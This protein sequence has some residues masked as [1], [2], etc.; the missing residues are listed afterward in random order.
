MAF[1]SGVAHAE[2]VLVSDNVGDLSVHSKLLRCLLA[3]GVTVNSMSTAAA[4]SQCFIQVG[5]APVNGN[6]TGVQGLSVS[7][8]DRRWWFRDLRSVLPPAGR[9][10]T[11]YSFGYQLDWQLAQ[12]RGKA[13]QKDDDLRL[14]TSVINAV[15]GS[16]VTVSIL[17]HQLW[18]V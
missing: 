12:G 2:S 7:D 6:Q 8:E 13:L 17:Q 5:L 3:V 18:E 14:C 16:T 9:S 10:A 1:N 15:A 11:D 4:S